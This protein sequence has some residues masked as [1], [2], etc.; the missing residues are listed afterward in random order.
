LLDFHSTF[1]FHQKPDCRQIFHSNNL[2]CALHRAWLF[3]LINTKSIRDAQSV[4]CWDEM[5]NRYRISLSRFTCQTNH[6]YYLHS[7]KCSERAQVK[8]EIHGIRSQSCVSLTQSEPRAPGVGKHALES[9]LYGG[10][11]ER[12]RKSSP[13]AA[14]A[15]GRMNLRRLRFLPAD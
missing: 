4:M 9:K 12:E 14:A 8:F 7:H 15:A 10:E 2:I 1:R 6:I 3:H 13:A 11:R 5:K